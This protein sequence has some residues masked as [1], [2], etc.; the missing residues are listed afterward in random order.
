MVV[1]KGGWLLRGEA[2]R[3]ATTE[4]PVTTGRVGE[5]GGWLLRGETH[6]P[7]TAD[8]TGRDGGC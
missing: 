5:K 3:P 6:R 4:A 1:A 8:T 2:H 7:V